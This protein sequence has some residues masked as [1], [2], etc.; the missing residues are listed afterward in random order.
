MAIK[1]RK[2]DITEGVRVV[3]KDVPDVSVGTLTV[4]AKR[5][6]K[7]HLGFH[8]VLRRNGS[9][10]KGIEYDHIADYELPHADTSLYVLAIG[11]ELNDAQR[12]G[13]QMLLDSLKLPL[14]L[15]EEG[16]E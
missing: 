12:Q 14:V 2:R 16:E 7:L 13:L 10:E 4:I 6:G 8:Y 11:T 15:D 5:D 9:I 1:F 3:I